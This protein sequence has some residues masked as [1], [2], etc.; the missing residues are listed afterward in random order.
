MPERAAD[1]EGKAVDIDYTMELNFQKFGLFIALLQFLVTVTEYMQL[2]VIL[3]CKIKQKIS[4]SN[5]E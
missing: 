3:Q 2:T 1:V 5:G 4:Y